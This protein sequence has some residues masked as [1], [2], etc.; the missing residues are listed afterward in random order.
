MSNVRV[1]RNQELPNPL[2]PLVIAGGAAAAALAS[3]EIVRAL[4][5]RVF[6][7]EPVPGT[8]MMPLAGAVGNLLLA[9]SLV[10]Y[11]GVDRNVEKVRLRLKRRPVAVADAA[12]ASRAA[13]PS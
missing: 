11:V 8:I 12:W 3:L 7:P 2:A 9:V 1:A 6:L 10:L 5:G 13:K 4:T